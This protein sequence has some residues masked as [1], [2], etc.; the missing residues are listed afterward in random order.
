MKTTIYIN[1]HKVQSN[2]K[3]E[4]DEPCIAIRDYK[5]VKYAKTVHLT[6]LWALKQDF[7]NPY[8]SGATIWLEGD[9]KDYKIVEDD[10][11]D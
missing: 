7:K 8:C 6:G 9:H 11:T 10:I 2:K 4:V 3:N 5:G 1:R